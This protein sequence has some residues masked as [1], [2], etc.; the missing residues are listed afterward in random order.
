VDSAKE[1]PPE[2]KGEPPRMSAS[3]YQAQAKVG[4]VTLAADF[5][6]HAVPTQEGTFASEEYVVVE[7]AIFGSTDARLK[8]SAENFSLKINDRKSALPSQPFEYLARSLKDPEWQPPEEDKEKKSKTGIN[9]GG[10]GDNGPPVVPKMPLPLR[11]A[12]DQKVLQSVLP[13]GERALPVDGLIF[14]QYRG[15]TQNIKQMELV[16]NGPAGSV[17]LALQP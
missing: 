7:V 12:M 17:S 2:F 16:Y 14:F 10:G 8:V 11:R 4:S 1:A 9:T 13:A 3:D 15:K 5:D 6:G